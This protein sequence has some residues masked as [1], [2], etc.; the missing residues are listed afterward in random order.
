M[1]GIVGLFIKD[2]RL[3]PS[4]GQMF[5]PMMKEMTDRGPDSSGIAVYHDHTSAG[6][7]K[8]TCFHP[9]AD[10]DWD[11]LIHHVKVEF[12]GESHKESATYIPRG[13]HRVIVTSVCP[14]KQVVDFIHAHYPEVIIASVGDYMEIY[15]AMGL[16]EEVCN[17][18]DVASMGGSHAIGH[19]RMATESAVTTAGSHPFSTGYNLCLVHNGSLSNHNRLRRN[20]K[21][22]SGFI[23]RTEN[24]TE[25]AAAYIAHRMSEGKTLS[26]ALRSSLNDLDGFFTFVAGT[27]D[28][29]AVMRDPIAC[30]PAVLAET[31]GYV[32]FASE[33][34]ALSHLPEVDQATVWEPEPAVVYSWG[35]V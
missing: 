22:V 14:A 24:D 21:K 18:F 1:C 27:H 19:T 6:E 32:A 2:D 33:F 17:H 12:A 3:R 11:A 25:V 34:R 35:G 10:F 15:K 30:K 31:D 23:F 26:D 16:P 20:I 8:I 28:G 5:V 9:D 29:F 4:M 13:S 7:S